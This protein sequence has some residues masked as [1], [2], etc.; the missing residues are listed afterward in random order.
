ML[1]Q[2]NIESQILSFI[3]SNTKEGEAGKEQFAKDLAKVIVDSIKS[4]TVV[5]LQTEGTKM[6]AGGYPVVISSPLNGSLE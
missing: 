5:I 6:N 4:A 2:A 1:I 3:N